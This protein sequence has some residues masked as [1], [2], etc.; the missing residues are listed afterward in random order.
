MAV[1]QPDYDSAPRGNTDAARHREKVHEA[2]RRNLPDILSDEAII[3]QREKRVVKVPIR[4]VKSYHF[5][6]GQVGGSGGGFGS[7]DGQEGAGA[8]ASGPSRSRGSR[9]S[10]AASR[11]WTTWRP[12]S[13]SR[14]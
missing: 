9:G 14:S 3:T 8:R 6:H 5:I 12:R 10:P 11:G 7:G 4:G 2:I 1:V 13:T